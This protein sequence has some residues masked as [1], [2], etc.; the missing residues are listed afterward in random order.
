M[1]YADG[2]GVETTGTARQVESRPNRTGADGLLLEDDDVGHG[3]RLEAAPADKSVQISGAGGEQVDGL[4]GAQ[5]AVLTN[6]ASEHVRGEA[7]A[8]D[9][10]EVGTRVGA[11]DDGPRISDQLVAHSPVAGGVGRERVNERCTEL[12]GHDDV[13]QHIEGGPVLLGRDVAD[14]PA[15]VA[16]RRR[17]ERLDDHHL[18]PFGEARKRRGGCGQGPQP[19][20]S[21]GAG[22]ERK[23]LCRRQRHRLGPAVNGVQYEAGAEGVAKAVHAGQRQADNLA[24]GR[25]GEIGD[26]Q[27]GK[28]LVSRPLRTDDEVPVH[29]PLGDDRHVDHQLLCL[30]VPQTDAREE[31]DGRPRKFAAR[32][33]QGD[34]LCPRGM[35]GRHRLTGGVVVCRRQARRETQC[36]GPQ[37]GPQQV[38]HPLDLFGSPLALARR[39]AHDDPP[40]GA[41]THHE[42]GVD[43]ERAV[44]TVQVVLGTGP[45]PRDPLLER[46]EGHSFNP[47]QHRHQVLGGR[48]VQRCDAEPTVATDRRRDAVERR[49]REVGVPEALHVEMGV[50][51]DKPRGNHQPVGVDGPGPRSHIGAD[52]R[53]PPAVYRY[54]RGPP[55][56]PGPVY[57][58][59]TSNHHVV[60][61]SPRPH[62]VTARC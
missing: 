40:Q 17:R 46:F 18:P 52:L 6:H 1:L 58:R 20:P 34:Q 23:L 35:A 38:P 10:V 32:L 15:L 9:H 41:V 29:R 14:H 36:S 54:V 62:S 50:N 2:T 56:R 21:F 3:S 26:V 60:H 57:H 4:L 61:V 24:A 47:G 53:H 55:G 28:R 59:T 16:L 43:G 39:L 11:S 13:E 5:Q 37:A 45:V 44:Q 12:V 42:P 22:Q 48:R 7:E 49:R 33:G 31:L 19:P 8:R 51:I 27:P 30:G 25:T